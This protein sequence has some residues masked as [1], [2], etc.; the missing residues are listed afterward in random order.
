[1]GT[2]QYMLAGSPLMVKQEGGM[3]G[4]SISETATKI[5]AD[6]SIPADKFELPAEV[7][8]VPNPAG[9]MSTEIA[10]GTFDALKDPNFEEKMRASQAQAP[11]MPAMPGM[12]SGGKGQPDP[13]QMMKMMEEMMKSLP[14]GAPK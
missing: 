1:M 6:V 2:K 11:S 14:Q 12:P 13:A 8:V 7:K 10:M 5:E 9:E 3:A 4:M